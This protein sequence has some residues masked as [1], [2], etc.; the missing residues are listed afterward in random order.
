MLATTGDGVS[1]TNRALTKGTASADR[2]KDE[3]SLLAVVGVARLSRESLLDCAV[4]LNCEG[5]S[6]EGKG[7][8]WLGGFCEG[9]LG[10]ESGSR[11]GTD[12]GN[13][14][15]TGTVAAKS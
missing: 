6:G 3:N 13:S 1:R 7:F 15:G 12:R 4:D 8:H 2:V 11:D 14:A 5:L 10:G 9:S